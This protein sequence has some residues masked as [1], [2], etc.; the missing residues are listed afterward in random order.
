MTERREEFLKNLKAERK[1]IAKQET[2]KIYQQ[3]KNLNITCLHCVDE[4]QTS[5]RL[6]YLYFPTLNKERM[7]FPNMC[8]AFCRKCERCSPTII[9]WRM[10]KE[11]FVINDMKNSPALELM[12]AAF[13]T[14][15]YEEEEG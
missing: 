6:Q 10:G 5:W 8:K 3:F 1:E 13:N 12:A 2:E 4:K 15:T 7:K 14:D 11:L 9:Y